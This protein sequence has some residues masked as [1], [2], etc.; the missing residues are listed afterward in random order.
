MLG[1]V[2]T[3]KYT[4]QICIMHEYYTYSLHK[5]NVWVGHLEVPW[6]IFYTNNVWHN[7]HAL[8]VN[9]PMAWDVQYIPL[10]NFFKEFSVAI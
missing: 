5:M 8:Y 2:K 1:S 4:L 3:A 6:Y 7:E 10:I 9:N